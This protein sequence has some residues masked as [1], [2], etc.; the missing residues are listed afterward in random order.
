[1]FASHYAATDG[2]DFRLEPA[3]AVFTMTSE[4]KQVRLRVG[5]FS[6]AM[7]QSFDF[8]V[9]RVSHRR[10]WTFLTYLAENNEFQGTQ[11]LCFT[12]EH[13]FARTFTL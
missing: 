7:N 12:R 8:G 2:A 1:M 13:T 9:C 10:F 4:A 11:M 6:E 3:I 5:V